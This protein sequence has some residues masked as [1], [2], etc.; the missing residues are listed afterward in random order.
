MLAEAGQRTGNRQHHR[1][2][3]EAGSGD[4]G[5]VPEASQQACRNAIAKFENVLETDFAKRAA[6]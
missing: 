2:L 6:K 1:S 3:A 4:F 5:Q